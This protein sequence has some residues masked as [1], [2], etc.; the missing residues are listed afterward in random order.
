[1][2]KSVFD[3]M[4]DTSKISSLPPTP[5]QAMWQARTWEPGKAYGVETVYVSGW[6]WMP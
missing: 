2:S 3:Q 1:V 5:G 6:W 4:N